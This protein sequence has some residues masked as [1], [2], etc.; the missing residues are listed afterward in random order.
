MLPIR[1]IQTGT[2]G[3]AV[4]NHQAPTGN[5]APRTDGGTGPMPQR[6][7]IFLKAVLLPLGLLAMAAAI[8]RRKPDAWEYEQIAE[9]VAVE[10]PAA[11]PLAP[12]TSPAGEALRA[13]S[14]VLRPVLRRSRVHR[15]RR[16]PDGEADG[17]GRRRT[18]GS[19]RPDRLAR[20]RNGGRPREHCPRGSSRRRRTR[21]GCSCRG[22]RS[23]G[24]PRR[25][26]TGRGPCRRRRARGSSR[27][28]A[29]RRRCSVDRR[30]PGC[31]ADRRC[32]CSGAGPEQRG[33]RR[34]PEGRLSSEGV[35]VQACARVEDEPGEEVDR[36]A[37]SRSAGQGPRGRGRARR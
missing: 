33:S 11:A 12:R 17:R 24:G 1:R 23:R 18:R 4:G 37:R 9:E 15:G 20:R 36:Q 35:R 5:P 16:R 2:V 13:R 21:R 6:K 25:G 8:F 29:C 34:R 26:C 19:V 10:K 31:R 14:R 3:G 27:G 28:R 32:R 22:C 7:R 30:S